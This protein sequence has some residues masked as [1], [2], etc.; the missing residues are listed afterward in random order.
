MANKDAALSSALRQKLVPG[1]RISDAQTH[2]ARGI[3]KL[4]PFQR[5]GDSE[6]PISPKCF[7]CADSRGRHILFHSDAITSTQST[8]QHAQ[9][10]CR[11]VLSSCEDFKRREMAGA[12][13]TPICALIALH[14]NLARRFVPRQGILECR[15]HGSRQPNSVLAPTS[16][17][18]RGDA[19]DDVLALSVCPSCPNSPRTH[20]GRADH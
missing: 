2:R 5:R 14:P 3:T 1:V 6:Q 20:L 19:V 13:P 17:F 12:N 7:P 15:R 10:R 16:S 11:C 8:H 18:K 9:H 4:R